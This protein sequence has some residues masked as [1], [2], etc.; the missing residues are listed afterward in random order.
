[1]KPS[2][3]QQSSLYAQ[4]YEKKGTKGA[5]APVASRHDLRNEKDTKTSP[6]RKNK[7]T[8]SPTKAIAVLGGGLVGLTGLYI[9]VGEKI[10]AFL[11]GEASKPSPPSIPPTPV[12]FEVVAD[13][14]A[15]PTI[16][17]TAPKGV[18][19]LVTRMRDAVHLPE[20]KLVAQLNAIN[21]SPSLKALIMEHGGRLSETEALI[22]A[23]QGAFARI[24]A[25]PVGETAQETLPS[26]QSVVETVINQARQAVIE[27]R[28]IDPA[29]VI[30]TIGV[31]A[32]G[33]GLLK[34]GVLENIVHIPSTGHVTADFLV[35]STATGFGLL[36]TQAPKLIAAAR[37]LKGLN[38]LEETLNHSQEAM[39]PV[40]NLL[41]SYMA[42]FVDMAEEKTPEIIKALKKRPKK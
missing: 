3:S 38:K 37:K 20:V 5:L 34:A 25:L 4:V 19:H 21:D 12:L 28:R 17:V 41:V 32:V 15:P 11:F 35:A 16:A 31:A 27:N 29:R 26:V 22:N 30:E 1:M 8:F 6:Q 23:V 9:G 7:K 10:K 2:L 24:Q 18:T 14:P 36:G 13:V 39:H 40:A 33:T 42:S